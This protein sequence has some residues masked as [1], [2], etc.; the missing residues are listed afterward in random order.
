MGYSATKRGDGTLDTSTID[1]IDKSMLH[2]WHTNAFMGPTKIFWLSQ[3]VRYISQ[4]QTWLS[5]S[6]KMIMEKQLNR[7][8]CGNIGGIP[9][10]IRHHCDA[11][12]TTFCCTKTTVDGIPRPFANI[13]IRYGNKAIEAN[14]QPLSKYMNLMKKKAGHIKNIFI[15]T[16]TEW[17]IH[18]LAK[19][20][21]DYNFFFLDYH[22][23]ERMN[24]RETDASIDYV[25]ELVYSFAN[26]YIAVEADFFVGS[27][28]SSWC[29]L[30]HQL[31]RT[32]GDGGVDYL[33]VDVGSQYTSCF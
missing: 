19:E 15:S 28:T 26:L 27:L 30:I 31:E 4:P 10:E 29:V 24:L 16:E 3:F 11:I 21:S 20:Y 8:N 17:V 9:L 1:A 2:F 32:R 23:V 22:R 25:H 33:S 14:L 12:D 7:M 13:H 6:L 18:S 5:M